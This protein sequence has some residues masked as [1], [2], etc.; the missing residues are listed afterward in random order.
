MNQND[1]YDLWTVLDDLVDFIDDAMRHPGA[2][3]FNP[4]RCRR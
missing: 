1:A 3:Q 4:M 2:P